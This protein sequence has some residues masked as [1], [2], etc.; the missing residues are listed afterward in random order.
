MKC[1]FRL[2]G[3]LLGFAVCAHGETGLIRVR[4]A[5]TVNRGSISLADLLPSGVPDGV[6][7]A[8]RALSLGNAPLPGS[9][10]IFE[11]G[12]LL[13]RL[14]GHSDLLRRL[15]FPERVIVQRAS[16]PISRDA[17]QEAIAAFLHSDGAAAPQVVAS[18]ILGWP[19]TVNALTPNPVLAVTSSAWD[20]RQQTLAFRLHCV[21]RQLCGDFLVETHPA[22]S[23]IPER[24]T[25]AW[26]G[27]HAVAAPRRLASTQP[28]PPLVQSGDPAML[29]LEEGGIRISLPV[30]CLQRGGL[31]EQI[32]ARSAVGHR[33]FRAEVVN[34]GEL[35]A[36]F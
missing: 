1:V 16:W 11:E 6:L 10:R 25:T 28:I 3:M 23:K 34:R 13:A 8:S 27:R 31:G 22:Q 4:G 35:R 36:A 18:S 7:S 33:V 17:I 24:P 30:I 29:V 12:Q 15:S 26:A 20:P 2:A 14:A 5:V 19:G 9:P 32:R 21:E